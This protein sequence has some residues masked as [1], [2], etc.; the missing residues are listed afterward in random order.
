MMRMDSS[1]S[2]PPQ[3]PP[4]GQLFQLLMGKALT[5]SLSA[6]ARLR[7]ADHMSESLRPVSEIATAAGVKPGPLF[8]VLRT[9][10]SVGVFHQAGDAF[11]LAP[12]GALLRSDAPKSL[13]DMAAMMGD[14]W[15][16]DA[17]QLLYRSLETGV[18]G[19]TL[20]YGK[21]LFE[22]FQEQ[23]APAATFHAAM[24]N[25][26]RSLIPHLLEAYDFSGIGKLADVGGGHGILLASILREY[27]AMRGVLFDLPEVLAGAGEEL[28]GVEDRVERQAGSFFETMPEGCDA[29]IMKHIIHD[30]DDGSCRRIL[31]LMAERLPAHG[32]V[33]LFEMVVPPGSDPAPV[34]LLDIEMLA[35]TPG[36]LERTA[37]EYAALFAASGLRLNRVVETRSPM[38]IVE[39]VRA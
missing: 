31:S 32:K 24:T 2:A 15:S 37:D 25:F 14:K 10:S 8:R 16:A 29:F 7:V 17:Y 23:P 30:W 27:P 9:L 20:A 21:H 3:I 26:T 34:K 1:T 33:L 38:C 13:R 22:L 12:M 18:D 5:F 6:I 39:A 35:N 4:D 28:A 36:G 19:V 11:G